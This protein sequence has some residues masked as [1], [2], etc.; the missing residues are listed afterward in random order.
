MKKKKLLV[1]AAFSVVM[2]LNAIGTAA[3]AVVTNKDELVL[4]NSG[5]P[6][7]GQKGNGNG[8]AISNSKNYSTGIPGRLTT[9]KGV[10]FTNNE[11]KSGG[12]AIYNI[13]DAFINETLFSKNT[14]SKTNG[15]GGAI[16][17]YGIGNLTID[18]STF[19]QN[20]ATQFGGAIAYNS[21][22]VAGGEFIVKNNT[23]ISGN[24]AEYGGG[25]YFK[26]NAKTTNTGSIINTTI[27]ENNAGKY[28]GGI[29]V[30]EGKLDIKDSVFESNTAKD[31]GGAL[32]VFEGSTVNITNTDFNKNVATTYDPANKL[33]GQGGAILIGLEN[34][35][36]QNIVNIVNSTF[37]ENRADGTNG[38]AISNFDT[39]T[40]KDS[41]FTKNIISTTTVDNSG[42]A[43]FLGAESKTKLDNVT[44][45]DNHST[46]NGG[47]IG[48]RLNADNSK[49]TLDITNSTFKNNT[50]VSFGGAIDNRFFGSKDGGG[51]VNIANSTFE[52]NS[53]EDGG[54]IFSTNKG[55]MN[56]TSSTFTKNS[57]DY[58]GAIDT[59]KSGGLVKIIDSTFKENEALSTGAVG[60]F[61]KMEILDSTFIGNKATLS[62]EDGGGAV[63]LGSES[64]TKIIGGVFDGN[65]SASV[66]GAIATRDYK[67]NNSAAKLDIDGAVFTNNT[68]EGK[69]GALYN[70]FY[71]SETKAN[72]VSVKNAVFDNNKSGSDG[73][74]IYNE[75]QDNQGNLAAIDIEDTN[76]TNNSAAG[77]G[78]AIFS[79]SDLSISAVTKNVI[80]ADNT[81]S[82]GADIYMNKSAS[83]LTFNASENKS[84]TVASG[85]SGQ[86]YDIAVN[87]AA[88]STGTIVVNSAIKNAA[89]DV[90]QGTF[91][92]AQGSALENSKATIAK[93][94]TL[95]TI[96][97]EINSFT[98]DNITLAD[99][100]KLSVDINLATGKSDNFAKNVAKGKVEI[101]DINPLASSASTEN[102]TINLIEALGLDPKN[103]SIS[104]ALIDETKTILT[105]I[106]YLKGE[107]SESGTVAFAPAG[108][109]YKDFNPSV[110]AGAIAAQL[111]GYLTQL[112]SYDEAFRNMDMYM[113]MTKKQRQ[114]LKLR[115]KYAAA[116]GNLV[117]DP[118]GTPH[119]DEAGWV[120]P[121]ST[122]E[123]VRLKGGPRVSNV[124]YGSFFG[125]D[126][127]LY[128]LGHGWDGMWG[129]YIGYNG[130]HQSYN[131]ISMYQNGGTL[132][133]VGMAYKGNFFTGLTINAGANGGEASTMYGTDNFSMLMAGIASKTGYNIE[134]ADGKFIIQPSYLMSYS[135]VN[136]FDYTNAAGVRINSDPLNAIQIEPGLKFIGNLKNGWQPYAS[137][138]VVWN[139]MDKTDFHA[140]DVSLPEL[141]IK[142][143]VRYGIGVRKT[144][145]ER[146]S[147]FLQTYFTN[148]G[149]NGV[150]FQAGFRWTLG[151]STKSTNKPNKTPQLKKTEIKLGN[152]K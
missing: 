120:R 56:I 144:W 143:F 110:M 21:G 36:K 46:G 112:N 122:F 29:Y 42:G 101:A 69:G 25:I 17:N 47:A 94:A 111:G 88:G 13:A 76:F 134:L 40:I 141:S 49:A 121:Y 83:T 146:F 151:R 129:A 23:V 99:G 77:K 9:T 137:V 63:F 92:L 126:S 130:S 7:S 97:N 12:G 89:I 103:V 140:N 148:G 93:G 53:S 43:L 41:T 147:G 79:N 27:K 33:Y 117:F 109:K 82:D 2:A 95:N 124:A 133:A 100:A 54:A 123:N 18:N 78:G 55:S 73:G 51:A 149:R 19:E 62:S 1:A 114:A 136:T 14:I 135:F 61:A 145:G 118:T 15:F 16:Y 68:A 37:K 44:F 26:Q 8:G 128:D 4:P 67:K 32:A 108:N 39:L 142:P 28:G 152:N 102:V 115:N 81:A 150:G 59:G 84:I 72:T 48:T 45:E 98:S 90:Q 96:N 85:I 58:G 64:T 119:S 132:G 138:S 52:G 125:A 38:G 70:S 11:A 91:H 131:G 104:K 139:I 20:S 80:L 6:T 34:N 127:E 71:N 50:S 35:N 105:P 106:R 116:D 66:G 86:T 87:S 57:A 30:T 3:Y 60:N 113:L 22:A 65:T 31:S 75:I 74:A 24:Q 10:E 5:Y 107:V